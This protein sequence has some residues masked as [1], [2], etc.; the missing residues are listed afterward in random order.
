MSTALLEDNNE[1]E[2][3][4]EPSFHVLTWKALRFTK[5]TISRCGLN[6]L[7]RA[8]DEVYEDEDTVKGE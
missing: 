6:R 4:Q 5:H 7:L 8:Y 1:F 3:D 2:D